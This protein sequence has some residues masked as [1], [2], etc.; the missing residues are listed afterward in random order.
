MAGKEPMPDGVF[1]PRE[2]HWP[3]SFETSG[4]QNPQSSGEIIWERGPD[5]KL[6]PKR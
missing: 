2:G 3:P 5:G 6:G 4:V 1:E